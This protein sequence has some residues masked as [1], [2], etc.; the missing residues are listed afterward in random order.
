MKRI[1]TVLLAA[2]LAAGAAWSTAVAG[3]KSHYRDVPTLVNATMAAFVQALNDKS[4]D[5]FAS[6]FVAFDDKAQK[7]EQAYSGLYQHAELFAEMGSFAP[8]VT[9]LASAGERTGLT[10]R[11]YYPGKYRITYEMLFV[12]E[13]NELK[14]AAFAVK[15]IPTANLDA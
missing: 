8:V 1:A 4:M 7:L 9:E 10:V 2:F 3:P 12:L 5:R 11:G 14:L 6:R 15:V 13:N